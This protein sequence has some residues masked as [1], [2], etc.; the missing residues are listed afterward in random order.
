MQ[1]LGRGLGLG[2]RHPA[3]L[4]SAV[5]RAAI[6]AAERREVFDAASFRI[7]RGCRSLRSASART[8]V[9]SN[10]AVSITGLE[11]TAICGDA[12]VNA[13]QASGELHRWIA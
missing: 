7:A 2:A 11:V 3:Q 5:R 12:P 9:S 4:R 1:R 8:R 6:T 10:P 13:D